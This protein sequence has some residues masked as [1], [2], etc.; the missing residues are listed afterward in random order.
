MSTLNA[1]VGWDHIN[2]KAVQNDNVLF[3]VGDSSSSTSSFNPVSNC[4]VQ[5]VLGNGT[6]MI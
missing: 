5:F 6:D 4:S 3:G 2:E 1:R